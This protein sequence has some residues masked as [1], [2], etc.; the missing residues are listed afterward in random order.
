MR[1]PPAITDRNMQ[2]IINMLQVMEGGYFNQ[3]ID[4]LRDWLHDHR[5]Y[6]DTAEDNDMILN[7]G[8]IR[9]LVHLIKE[10]DENRERYN[11]MQA[12]R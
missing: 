6:A 12:R 10:V 2:I 9:L 8:A 4:M 7:Q 5:V 3:F 1:Q 11:K